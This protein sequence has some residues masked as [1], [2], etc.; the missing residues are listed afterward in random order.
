MIKLRLLLILS[1]TMIL[2]GCRQDDHTARE[3]DSPLHT[4]SL[5]KEYALQDNYNQFETLMLAGFDEESITEFYETVRRTASNNADIK[6]V[7][8]VTFDNGKTL[9]VHLTPADYEG[10]EVLIQDVIELPTEMANYIEDVLNA[11]YEKTSEMKRQKIS[12]Q[13]RIREEN[14]FEDYK[15]ITAREQVEKALDIIKEADWENA[16]AEMSR[17]PDLQFQFPSVNDDNTKLANYLLWV[18]PNGENLEIVT[19]GG[20]Y[21]KLAKQDSA[22]LFGIVTD[23]SLEAATI[24]DSGNNEAET[25]I[26]KSIEYTKTHKW[27][28]YVGLFDFEPEVGEHLLSFLKDGEDQGK[29][30]GIHGIQDIKVVSMELTSDPEFISKGDYVYDVLLDMKVLTPSD[31]YMN[32]ISRHIYVPNRVGEGLKIETVYLDKMYEHK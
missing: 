21:V 30:D 19:D 20:K 11:K 14:L 24:V 18:T 15:E 5:M 25:L 26:H 31:I 22:D 23:E 29:L 2:T 9:L 10:G 4:T 27:D 6:N 17:F 12:I 7:T 3:P 16:K 13:K 8:L 28:E 1:L 32:G